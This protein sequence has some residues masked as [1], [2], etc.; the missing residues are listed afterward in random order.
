[1]QKIEFPVSQF[2]KGA[3]FYVD[4]NYEEDK[5]YKKRPVVM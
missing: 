1:M 3:V 5:R 4:F 2:A